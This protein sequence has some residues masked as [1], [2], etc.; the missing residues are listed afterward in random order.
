MPSSPTRPS[1]YGSTPLSP[2]RTSASAPS[3]FRRLLAPFRIRASPPSHDRPHERQPLIPSQH[4]HALRESWKGLKSLLKF[5]GPGY[6][7]AIGYLD[8]GNWATDLAAGSQFNYSLLIV[9]LVSNFMAVLLQ[10]LCIRLGVVTGMDLASACRKRF[11]FPVTLFFYILCELAIMACD[12]AEV[13]GSAIALNILFSIPL[14]VGILITALD[15]LVILAAWRTEHMQWFEAAIIVL[16]A[17]VAGCFG[18][19]VALSR[20]DWGLVAA[21]FMPS[22]EIW[23]KPGSLYVAMGILG[24][25]VMPHNLYLHSHLVRYRS[26]RDSDALGEI[27]EVEAS[28]EPDE[29]TDGDKVGLQPL[30]RAAIIRKTLHLTNIDSTVALTFALA[31][32]ASILIVSAAS[33][34]KNNEKDVADLQDAFHL[35][36]KFLGPVAG[37]AFGV[38]LL[39]S[40]QSST[41]TGT[42]TGQIIMEGFLGSHF[43]VSPWARRLITRLLAIVPAMVVTLW[44]GSAGIN[45]LLIA[46]QVV[47]SLQLPFAVWPLVVFTNSKSMMRVQYSSDDGDVETAV[48]E[49]SF[50]NSPLMSVASIAIAVIITALNLGLIYQVFSGNAAGTSSGQAFA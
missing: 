24:A 21:G 18:Y 36:T 7:V 10:S 44:K 29:H 12:L 46:S 19:L 16:V 40:G 38:A 26:S 43:R 49:E 42:M 33:F 11:S 5:I 22:W 1:G 41:I 17:A 45:Q 13:I 39:I 48:A 6:M 28:P 3:L 9:I 47:L 31:I 27:R 37:T 34:Y 4:V 32:N 8:P 30:C 20:P 14:P 50:Q 23:T 15:V 25:T 2:H 35:I